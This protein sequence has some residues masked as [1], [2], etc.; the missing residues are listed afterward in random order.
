MAL[1]LF[2]MLL[3]A[4]A[5]ILSSRWSLLQVQE[6]A[7]SGSSEALRSQAIDALQRQPKR[8]ASNTSQVLTSIKLIS[9]TASDLLAQGLAE[10]QAD[11]SLLLSSGTN[12]WRY[13]QGVTTVLVPPSADAQA[14]SDVATS[15][16][17]DAVFPGFARAFPE[18]NRISY[19]SVGGVYRTFP[20]SDLTQLP[21]SMLPQNNPAF[22]AQ[23][24]ERN[25][26]GAIVWLPPHRAITTPENI[27][28]AVAPVFL[29]GTLMGVVVVDIEIDALTAKIK[30]LGTELGGFGFLVDND[31]HLIAAPEHGQRLLLGEL[32]QGADPNTITLDQASP[33]FTPVI[34]AMRARTTDVITVDL[35]GRSYLVLYEPIPEM[36]WNVAVIAPVDQVTAPTIKIA[37]EITSIANGAIVR[38]VVIGVLVALLLCAAVVVV[39]H[40]QFSRPLAHLIAATD[41]IAAGQTHRINATGRDELGQLGRAFNTMADAL[42]QSRSALLEANHRLEHT[43]QE[44]TSELE[45]TIIQLGEVSSSQETLLRALRD[46]STPVIPITSGV[47]AMPLIGLLDSQRIHNATQALLCR[48][49]R[50]GA[51]MVLLDITGVPL[52][53]TAV[54]HALIQ[55]VAASTLLGAR[56]VLVGVTPEVAQT[57]VGLG[58]PMH[59]IQ[60]AADIQA[61]IAQLHARGKHTRLLSR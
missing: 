61:A 39:L 38:G 3:L 34:A 41:A 19:L 32:P 54:A 21:E 22:Q 12:G 31:G 10:G 13:Q 20:Q 35:Q 27:I 44:R 5:S 48:I 9:S 30:D 2:G 7:I 56:V 11:P 50:D 15:G 46:V 17:M 6:R 51:Q 33:A 26:S 45:Q 57:L 36:Q 24:P 52:I 47:L 60:T 53:D 29:R 49:E 37:E 8:R 1:F 59:D 43:V 25:P 58:I 14:L 42:D 23:Q 4:A 28:S 18:I 16:K 55:M 40:L